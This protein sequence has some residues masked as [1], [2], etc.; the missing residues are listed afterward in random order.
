MLRNDDNHGDDG[1]ETDDCDD[2]MICMA[3]TI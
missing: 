1:D 3:H 2:D